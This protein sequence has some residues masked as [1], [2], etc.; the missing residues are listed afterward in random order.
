MTKKWCFRIQRASHMY[1]FPV[2][3]T[4]CTRPGRA[5][6]RKCLNM[7]IGRSLG[8]LPLAKELLAINDC[9]KREGLFS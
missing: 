9:W 2:I 6:T 5:Q 3:V 1:E 7:E 8:V 4:A